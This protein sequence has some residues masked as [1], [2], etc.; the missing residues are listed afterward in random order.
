LQLRRGSCIGR[1]ILCEITEVLD[2]G[3]QTPVPFVLGKEGVLVEEAMG[4]SAMVNL[5][6]GGGRI[7]YP[8]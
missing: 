5:E 6:H 2:L 8:E 4:S 7:T 1:H 3:L